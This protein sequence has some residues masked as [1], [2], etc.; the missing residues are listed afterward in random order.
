MLSVARSCLSEA[1]REVW[2]RLIRGIVLLVKTR[3]E[4]LVRWLYTLRRRMV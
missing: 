3:R 2:M 4:R 1:S